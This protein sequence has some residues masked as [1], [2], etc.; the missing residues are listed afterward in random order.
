M[1]GAAQR[2]RT[3]AATTGSI[4]ERAAFAPPPHSTA[5][6]TSPS[7]DGCPRARLRGVRERVVRTAMHRR[8][9][10]TESQKLLHEASYRYRFVRKNFSR[11]HS[12]GRNVACR[13]RRRGAPELTLRLDPLIASDPMLVVGAPLAA[14]AENEWGTGIR[15]HCHFRGPR[16]ETQRGREP[17]RRPGV[18][19]TAALSCDARASGR[20]CVVLGVKGPPVRSPSRWPERIAPLQKVVH[21]LPSTTAAPAPLCSSDSRCRAVCTRRAAA[22]G[23]R[24]HAARLSRPVAVAVRDRSCACLVMLS[25]HSSCASG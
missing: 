1:P 10:S 23:R 25:P 9:R 2:R 11:L 3:R 17:A 13:A 14:L 6:A 19:G 5:S 4:H 20:T 7:A 21:L 22:G 16:H 15:V 12:R 18:C 8:S 24:H